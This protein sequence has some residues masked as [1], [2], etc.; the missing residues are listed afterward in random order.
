VSTET[1]FVLNREDGT[2]KKI[3]GPHRSIVYGWDGAHHI[4]VGVTDLLTPDRRQ[5]WD[6][7]LVDVESGDFAQL[8]V[9]KWSRPTPPPEPYLIE[10]P[11][12]KWAFLSR[13][14]GLLRT[15]YLVDVA[16]TQVATIYDQ[17]ASIDD[18]CTMWSEDSQWILYIPFHGNSPYD[19][20]IFLFHPDDLSSIQLSHYHGERRIKD[21]CCLKWSPDGEWLLFELEDSVR[22]NQVC[23]IHFS[24]APDLCCFDD[25]VVKSGQI[26]W[27]SDSRSV[28]FLAT[29]AEENDIYILDVFSG[30]IR[31]LTNDGN[32]EIAEE[33]IAY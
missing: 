30:E 9:P 16:G 12:G 19:G 7:F 17:P 29:V 32:L 10:S 8:E 33:L 22:A 27:G 14:E 3:E 21:I 20:N 26:V 28:A 25:I 2:V 1:L 15:F 23:V 4:R 6:W 31:N 11:D 13:E 24:S 18:R 5:E